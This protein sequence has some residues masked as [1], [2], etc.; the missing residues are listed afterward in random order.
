[1]GEEATK[2]KKDPPPW[3]GSIFQGSELEGG[4]HK[5]TKVVEGIFTTTSQ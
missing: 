2:K 1:M 4:L 3:E 5:A